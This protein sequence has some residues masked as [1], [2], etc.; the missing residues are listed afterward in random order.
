MEPWPT[1]IEKSNSTFTYRHSAKEVNTVGEFIAEW[2]ILNDPR[3]EALVNFQ[4]F[5][6]FYLVAFTKCIRTCSI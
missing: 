1:V 5:E 4:L 3:A 2:P 6:I